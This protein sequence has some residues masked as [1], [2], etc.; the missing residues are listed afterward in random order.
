L[1]DGAHPL[2]ARVLVNQLWLHHFG[3]GIVA[4]PGDF[5]FL[6][7][8]PTHPELLDWLASDFVA[9]GWKLKR[10][11]KLLMTSTV[12]R[13]VSR[14]DEERDRFDPDNRFFSRMPVRRL[15]AE[16]FRDAI[17][18]VSGKLHEKMFGPAVPVMEDE[19][20]QV[21]LGIENLNGEN[22]PDK[23]IPLNGEEFRRSV[24]VQVR[25]SRPLAVLDTFD[26][27]AMEP[28]C[29]ARPA[30]TVAPQSLLMM[31]NDFTLAQ[32]QASAARIAAEAGSE[33]ATQVAL[34]WRLHLGRDITPDEQTKA[35]AFLQAQTDSFA[36][37]P[38]PAPMNA[39]DPKPDHRQQ[40][41]AL[42]CHALLSSNEFLYVD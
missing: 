28:H 14:R 3:R 39:S 37:A 31:N 40:A 1:T 30:S 21:V 25:R 20:G 18:A 32:S 33:P 23:L 11:H 12:Y 4:T 38:P 27:P 36:K 10:L 8:R 34:A 35:V 9:G 26:L 13:Q 24:Y 29:V 22:R 41:L 16:A 7:E 19:V 17:L 15:E 42:L 6:G 5:G 2:T